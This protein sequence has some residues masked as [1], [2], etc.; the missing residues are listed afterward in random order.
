[1]V[2]YE[3]PYVILGRVVDGL[4]VKTDLERDVAGDSKLEGLKEMIDRT[5]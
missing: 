4:M 2:D 5:N 3:Q 1:M